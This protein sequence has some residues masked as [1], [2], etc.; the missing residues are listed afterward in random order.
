MGARRKIAATCMISALAA[1]SFTALPEPRA[2]AQ[3][4]S[5]RDSLSGFRFS[6]RHKVVLMPVQDK[7]G[8]Q[9]AALTDFATEVF[10]QTIRNGGVRTI[11]WF[12]V[13]RQLQNTLSGGGVGG[14]DGGRNGG[15]GGDGGSG[16]GGAQR[17][18][19]PAK[20]RLLPM[21]PWWNAN[22]EY[23]PST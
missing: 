12:K 22:V 3:L 8:G 10:N 4:E 14:A 18:L 19:S 13:Q 17:A 15:I 1:A 11:A 7:S 20:S 23:T 21:Q 5:S 2:H 16:G 9:A 6:T